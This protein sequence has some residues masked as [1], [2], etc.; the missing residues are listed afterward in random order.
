MGVAEAV[1]RPSRVCFDEPS[2]P[3]SSSSAADGGGGVMSTVGPVSSLSS[4]TPTD[5]QPSSVQQLRAMQPTAGGCGDGQPPSDAV[6]PY[7]MQLIR[8]T[9]KDEVD[10]VEERL[11]VDVLRTHLDLVVRTDHLQVCTYSPVYYQIQFKIATLT[12]KTLATC[13]PSYLYNLL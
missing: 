4:I 8:T 12:Y 7:L 9:V 2:H 3:S 11:H 5:A 6:P 1:R 10:D 13:Q